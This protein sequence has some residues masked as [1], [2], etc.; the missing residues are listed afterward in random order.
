MCKNV[1]HGKIKS[2]ICAMH[3][4]TYLG[5]YQRLQ[6]SSIKINYHK[7]Q[8]QQKSCHIF[9]MKTPMLL[10]RKQFSTRQNIRFDSKSVLL[11]V[12]ARSYTSLEAEDF[13]PNVPLAEMIT[14]L[15]QKNIEFN[16][17]NHSCLI[18]NVPSH[19]MTKQAPDLSW[20]A[21][22]ESVEKVYINKETGC[23]LCPKLGKGGEWS[24]LK[25]FLTIWTK[26][27]DS[28]INKKK[29]TVDLKKFPDIKSIFP[30]VSEN[31]IHGYESWKEAK[32]VGDL[33]DWEFRQMLKTFKLL[34]QKD[35]KQTVFKDYEA[36]L[37]KN[38]DN[39]SYEAILFPIKY[40]D[41]KIIGFRRLYVKEDGA[42]EEESMYDPR[43]NSPHT[44]IPFPHG[45]DRAHEKAANSIVLV[46]SIRDSI[47][48]ISG[49][50]SQPSKKVPTS[51][52]SGN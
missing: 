20:E 25:D 2:Q 21:I 52:D 49:D 48:I 51:I 47:A 10:D 23:F 46:S 40:I 13:M 7:Q 15:N 6:N 43:L 35:F 50:I 29:K 28:K 27:R 17:D 19:L 37:L 30:T 34:P 33:D 5:Q 44:V 22:D 18:I 38:P 4:T 16:E 42:I 26:S 24:L 8:S 45:L 39:E 32:P 36:K 14:F 11:K 31:E 9:H 12:A 3:T 41:G 1:F